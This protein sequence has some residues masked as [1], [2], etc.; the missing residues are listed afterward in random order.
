VVSRINEEIITDEWIISLQTKFAL[1]IAA[2]AVLRGMTILVRPYSSSGSQESEMQFD[3][4][5]VANTKMPL[6]PAVGTVNGSLSVM[7]PRNGESVK[8]VIPL[9]H[10]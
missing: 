8:A 6:P 3:A 5:I 10:V 9:V 2:I 1:S 7:Q 4:S